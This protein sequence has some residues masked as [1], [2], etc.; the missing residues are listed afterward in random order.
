LVIAA[1]VLIYSLF[2]KTWPLPGRP[3]IDLLRSLENKE[4][5]VHFQPSFFSAKFL[6]QPSLYLFSQSRPF[7][8]RE[9]VAM[10]DLSAAPLFTLMKLF[11][12]ER[13]QQWGW[14][15]AVNR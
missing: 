5:P 11:G 14:F 10:L 9:Q 2:F 13:F 1:F 4:T 15:L 3:E 8:S 6:F 7:S 12:V